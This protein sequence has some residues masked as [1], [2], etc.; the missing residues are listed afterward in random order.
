MSENCSLPDFSLE[1]VMFYAD[2][3]FGLTGDFRLLDGERDLN[4][5]VISEQGKF[6]FKIANANE[7]LAML[8]CQHEIF[9]LLHQNEHF[10]DVQRTRLSL[11]GNAIEKI[12]SENGGE[13]FC[14]M[15]HFVEGKLLSEID[16]ITPDLLDSLGKKVAEV[17]IA[18]SGF[19]HDGVNRPL[20]WNMMDGV[21][22]LDRFV[23]LI[24]DPDRVELIEYFRKV[25]VQRVLPVANELRVGIIHNDAN[26]NN[27]LVDGEGPWNLRVSSIIDYGDITHGW[28]AADPAIAAA[29]A[30]LGETKSRSG[31]RSRPLD[32]AASVIKGY[33]GR[34]P[35]SETE[36]Q[37]LFPMI[38]MRLCMSV[39]IC[40]YQQSLE[41]DNTYLKISETPAWDALKL[42]K[43]ISVDYVH[44]V[45]RQ[46]CDL[47][48]VPN[49]DKIM[50]WL[51]AGE[52]EFHSIVDVDLK[53]DPLFIL[54]TSVASPYI[55]SSVEAYDPNRATIELFRIIEDMN[56]VAGIGKYDEYRL[57]YRSDDFVDATGHQRTLHIGLDIFMAANSRIYAPLEGR[58]YAI[59][60]ND[61]PLDYGGTVIL[62]H[63]LPGHLCDTA[64]DRIYFYTLY[65]HLSP[66]SSSHLRKGDS[67]KAGQC[68]AT[69]GEIHENGNW[70][71]HVHF[72]IVTD[73][74]GEVDTFV[75]VGSHGHKAVWRSLCPDPNVILGIDGTL[76]RR[77]DS[78][79]CPDDINE[80]GSGFITESN[81][82]IT[83]L[84]NTRN[85]TLNPSLSLSYRDPIHAVRGEGQ[86][87]YDYTGRQYLDAVNN[88]PHVGHCHPKVVDAQRKQS[89]VLN[90]NTRYLYSS[91]TE[92]SQ[93]LVDLFPDPLSVCFLV[94]SGSEANDLALRLARNFTQKQDVVILDHAYHGSLGSL[95]DISPYKHDGVG[96]K[97]R[98]EYV[99]KANIPDGFRG[100]YRSSNTGISTSKGLMRIGEKYAAL[101]ND[102]LNDAEKRGGAAAFIA[103]SVLGCGGQIVLPEGYLEAVYAHC[104]QHGAVCIA[105]EVQVGF[106]RV[107]THLWG[108]ETQGVV[109]DIVTLGK[110][111]GNGHPLAGVITTREIADAFNNGMEYFN[112]FGGNPVS[113]AIGS[114]VID[115]MEEEG[116]QENARVVGAFLQQQ[117]KAL[118]PTFPI[119]GEV[120]GLGLFI[121]IEL[122]DDSVTLAPAAKQ[123]TYIAERMKQEGILISTDG[124]LHNVLKIK[125]P[126]CFSQENAIHFIAVL[127]D[128]LLEHY[129][130]PRAF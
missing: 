122:I 109:P 59:A 104:R 71:P 5:L 10:F 51:A 74:L 98:P 36:I 8:E 68:I 85:S 115:V 16:L 23:P 80:Q 127:H 121:G 72:E 110:P 64:G 97:G 46:V 108:F 3:F 28:I 26:D 32:I 126:L 9:E 116:L 13:H 19:Q 93:R 43:E 41:P 87:L 99:H 4:Y 57:I 62:Q 105:D 88:V 124:P 91:L 56:C 54:D 69:M 1:Q 44:F 25:F 21:S 11:L 114:A 6:V 15:V 102:A 81:S 29:Y 119:I 35:L 78:R 49:R 76:L 45:F 55:G 84:I 22:V 50:D 14:R 107:G 63:Q 7:S 18:L 83:Q 112:T 123:A 47:E 48:P 73:M 101:V 100:P 120:R 38:C 27:V 70:P 94:N 17:D 60:N 86:Y 24:S 61:A 128:I 129:A 58:V 106:G 65:G 125:P 20:L 34:Y 77:D 118:M 42:L 89:G 103:E 111:M 30:L 12:I 95:I 31:V 67:I 75:G 92:Y 33:H 96:G 117:L 52:V 79:P 82:Q 53:K 130:K 39:C 66:K 40:A 2:H 90:T 113:C 37:V